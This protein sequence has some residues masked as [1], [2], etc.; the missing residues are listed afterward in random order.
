MA[1]F[2]ALS[3][4]ANAAIR[5]MAM[6]TIPTTEDLLY[7]LATAKQN[8][9][10]VELPF[11][12]LHNNLNF[13]VRVVPGVPGT[14]QLHPRWYF[15]R[16][17]GGGPGG[18]NTPLWMRESSEVMMVQGKIKIEVNYTGVEEAVE[19]EFEGFGQ[20]AD[21]IITL[22]GNPS[23]SV[24]PSP[25]I[26][27]ANLPAM[28]QRTDLESTQ[29]W[30]GPVAVTTTGTWLF[31]KGEA[32][33]VTMPPPVALN[34]DLLK[35]YIDALSDPE[36]NLLRHSAFE[37]FLLRDAKYAR[38]YG[39]KIALLIFDFVDSDKQTLDL[40][41]PMKRALATLLAQQC[42]PLELYA[43][44]RTGEY[45]IALNGY[46]GPKALKFAEKL[47]L[48]LFD[49]QP[50]GAAATLKSLAIGASLP[51]RHLQ[52]SGDA[53]C[54]CVAG[55]GVGASGRATIY[56]FSPFLKGKN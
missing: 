40:Q 7:A 54:R 42:T 37:F 46:D 45:A 32:D 13:L 33:P 36:T 29:Q 47:C 4:N 38:Q 27:A 26:S 39:T 51:T 35:N 44:L 10:A 14:P 53:Y 56:A 24:G 16:C 21:S 55:K 3:S 25:A 28:S 23:A 49:G 11:K 8:K 2:H 20:Q 41:P 6:T 18:Q 34:Q 50:E 1:L 52:R 15:E 30:V 5:L 43:Q 48:A 22:P 9:K 17:D 31:Q 19:T 12:N